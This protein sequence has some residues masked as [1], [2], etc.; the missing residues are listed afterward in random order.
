MLP[1]LWILGL[2]GL[3]AMRGVSLLA[4]LLLT[5]FFLQ[6]IVNI[7]IDK[8]ATFKALISSTIMA[9][10]VLIAQQISYNII[11][12]PI[13]VLVGAATYFGCI[14]LLKV[15]NKSDIQLLEQIIGKRKTA[16]LARIL[17]YSQ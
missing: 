2:N 12:F 9:I 1:L 15:L 13:Y 7:E 4:S 10:V 3:A 6:K 16:I 14:R 5:M 17:K 11:L 8:Q